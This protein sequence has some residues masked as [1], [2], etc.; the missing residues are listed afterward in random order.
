MHLSDIFTMLKSA[1]TL[2]C[3][4]AGRRKMA[5]RSQVSGYLD[6]GS[7]MDVCV[8]KLHMK[9]KSGYLAKA[10]ATSDLLN[11]SAGCV[12]CQLTQIFIS[13]CVRACVSAC[14]FVI[15]VPW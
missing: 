12:L 3:V 13:V 4:L 10:T 7:I 9:F 15:Y 2:T 1:S 8:C 6:S 14:G 11:K 5:L